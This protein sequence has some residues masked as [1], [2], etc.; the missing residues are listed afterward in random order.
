MPSKSPRVIP[1]L[2]LGHVEDRLVRERRDDPRALRELALELP[3]TPT[4]VAEEEPQLRGHVRGDAA[5]RVERTRE[6]E[7]VREAR[8]FGQIGEIGT[9]RDDPAGVRLHRT[10]P[11]HGPLGIAV[12]LDVE[13]LAEI[14]GGEIRAA[15]QH[16]ADGAVLVVMDEQ[17]DGAPEV[18]IAEVGHRDE[19]RRRE[20]RGIGR[21]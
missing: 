5:Q 21:R 4:R 20:R 1:E 13:R 17:H 7:I 6:V 19:Q 10:A 3:G 14:G 9:A 16:E 18:R 2:F 15:V 8:R 12:P 11:V